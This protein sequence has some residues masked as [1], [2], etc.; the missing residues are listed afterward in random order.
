MTRKPKTFAYIRITIV[1]KKHKTEENKAAIAELAR[2]KNLGKVYFIEER[3]CGKRHWEDNE[4]SQILN[5]LNKGDNLIITKLSELGR[6]TTE[7]FDILNV[8]AKQRVNLYAVKE[9]R[10]FNSTEDW[11]ALLIASSIF[12]ELEKETIHHRVKEGMKIKK[13]AGV[14]MGRPANTRNKLDRH[15]KEIEELL[16]NGVSKNS[17]VKKFGVGRTTLHY[18]MKNRE[19][20]PL[21]WG[22]SPSIQKQSKTTSEEDTLPQ[23]LRSFIDQVLSSIKE[24]NKIE[25]LDYN[26][27]ISGENADILLYP[28]YRKTIQEF[29]RNTIPSSSFNLK[30]LQSIFSQVE[31]L[32]WNICDRTNS[33][34]SIEGI[35]NKQNVSLKIFVD[36]PNS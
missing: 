8:I 35:Y 1:D 12:S 36:S 6:N 13:L 22:T 10:Q 11:K 34:I 19:I 15:R 3:L 32:C 5:S 25:T 16:A 7:I 21:K 24:K 23:W 28:I 27:K 17:I 2:C 26:F 30:E 18:W 4:I 33:Y 20:D 14:K 31:S 9:N 29:T